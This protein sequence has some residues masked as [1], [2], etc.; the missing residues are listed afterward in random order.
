[1]PCGCDECGSRSRRPSPD[2]VSSGSGKAAPV[3]DEAGGKHKGER[4][5]PAEHV[6]G[7]V[8]AA[9]VGGALG[10]GGD[11]CAHRHRGSGPLRGARRTP[12]RARAPGAARGAPPRWPPPGAEPWLPPP[13]PEDP[14]PLEEPPPGDSTVACEPDSPDGEPEPCPPPSFWCRAAA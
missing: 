5:E 3:P 9:A 2:T 7:G 1:M 13:A 14:P 11:R 10:S 6:D 8:R 4:P 12:G